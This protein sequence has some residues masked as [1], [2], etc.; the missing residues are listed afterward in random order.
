VVRFHSTAQKEIHMPFI[1]ID[2]DDILYACSRHDIKDLIRSLVDEG[3]LPKEVLGENNE[4]KEELIRRGRLEEDFAQNL[5]KMKSKYY[6]LTQDEELVF[7]N[8]FKK[9]L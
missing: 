8:I 9:Y 2:I 3:H 4:V 6:S 7:E 5:E 1:D